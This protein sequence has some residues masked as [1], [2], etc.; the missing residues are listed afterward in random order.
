MCG[1]LLSVTHSCCIYTVVLP[2]K[3]WTHS[4]FITLRTAS[5]LCKLN[6]FFLFFYFY[7]LCSKKNICHFDWLL[8]PVF[9]RCCMVKKDIPRECKQCWCIFY[10]IENLSLFKLLSMT[11]WNVPVRNIVAFTCSCV[12]VGHGWDFVPLSKIECVILKTVLLLCTPSL[13]GCYAAF[14]II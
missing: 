2:I 7:G 9:E 11:G 4:T 14:Y 13:Y 8:L 10:M 1:L 3:F 12:R 6:S 5:Q